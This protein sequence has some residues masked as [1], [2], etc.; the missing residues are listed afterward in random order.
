MSKETKSTEIYVLHNLDITATNNGEL[1]N[2]MK[3][4]FF[5]HITLWVFLRK[6]AQQIILQLSFQLASGV[7]YI[8]VDIHPKIAPHFRNQKM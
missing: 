5:F 6:M 4:M 3:L 2:L 8:N 1:K 7:H